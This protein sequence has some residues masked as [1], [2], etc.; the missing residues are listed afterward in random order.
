[1]H[2]VKPATAKRD[3]SKS[4]DDKTEREEEKKKKATL[5]WKRIY[6]HYT[7]HF[8]VWQGVNN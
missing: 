5:C 3:T 8:N 1:L 6:A 2:V 7:N 4:T